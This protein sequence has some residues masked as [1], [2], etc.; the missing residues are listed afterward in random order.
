MGTLDI[1]E[2]AE[3]SY[4]LQKHIK[5]Y[6]L[7]RVL[8]VGTGSGIQALTAIKSVNVRE[9]VAIDINENAVKRLNAGVKEKK[10]RKINAVHSD[11]FENVTGHFNLI[12][13]N[14]PYLPQDKIAGKAV[15]D[16]ALYG[17][18]KGW[19][20]SERFFNEVSKNLFADGKILFLFSSL[21]NKKNI[22]EIIGHNL[23]EF[24][25][26][27][28]LKIAFEELYVYEIKKSS[29]LRKLEAKGLENI[30]YFA[31]GRRGMIYRAISDR[32]KLVKTHFPSKKDVINVAIKV[33]REESVA[34]E[35]MK[36]EAKWLKVL[37][38]HNIGP[39]LLFFG[40]NYLTYK[41][42]EGEFILDWVEKSS[43]EDI[44][45][46]LLNVLSQC[47]VMDKLKVN[48][49]EMHHPMK[50]ILVGNDNKPTL[51]DFERCYKTEKPHNVTQFVDFIC[52]SEKELGARKIVVDIDGLRKLAKEYKESYSKESFKE[53]EEEIQ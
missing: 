14:P 11:L 10:L 2:P 38:K 43:A 31:R 39:K 48:K 47:F 40:E 25:E 37:N 19:E 8:D 22:D 1:Y 9:V 51:I 24:V 44:K 32:S 7:G 29:L 52:R 42:V 53:I 50:H 26:I 41:F 13:F 35:R 4:L 5:K 30:Y 46:I 16:A 34:K 15:E 49:E 27:D 36:N 6:A 3:D 17:G 23:L 12:I 33:K 18:K 20:I 28:K 21:T 45:K